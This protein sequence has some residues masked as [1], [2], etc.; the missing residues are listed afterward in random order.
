MDIQKEDPEQYFSVV[1]VE[2]GT[3]RGYFFLE[4]NAEQFAT[5]LTDREGETFAVVEED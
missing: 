1:S 3:V 5:I 2:T 4:E